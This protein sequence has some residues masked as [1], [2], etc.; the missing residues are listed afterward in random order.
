MT[1]QYIEFILQNEDHLNQIRELSKPWNEWV[2]THDTSEELHNR[3]HENE[4]EFKKLIES[5]YFF[6][7][8]CDPF[9]C[10]QDGY[11]HALDYNPMELIDAIEKEQERRHTRK[12]KPKKVWEKLKA[13]GLENVGKK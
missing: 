13:Y 1:K 9:Y 10:I 2:A 5:N 3:M 11:I 7:E 6:D 12:R 8:D 4:T